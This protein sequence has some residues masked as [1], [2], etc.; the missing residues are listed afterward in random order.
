MAK[1][2]LFAVI[3]SPIESKK[4]RAIFVNNKTRDVYYTD[5]GAS[6]YEDYT[7]HKDPERRRLYH[8][9][10][11]S[12]LT[13]GDKYSAGY[14]SYFILWGPHTDIKKNIDEYRRRFDL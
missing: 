8:A 6:Q 13:K 4:Y 12:D 10:H 14:L 3:K 1:G 9:R 5:F 11:V 7:T 2:K